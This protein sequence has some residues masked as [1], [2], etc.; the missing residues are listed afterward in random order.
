MK[1][2]LDTNVISD[3]ARGDRSVQTE[4]RAHA[5]SDLAVSTVTVMERVSLSGGTPLS[6]AVIWN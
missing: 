1:Y 2:L 4:L 6:V 3:F 5:P